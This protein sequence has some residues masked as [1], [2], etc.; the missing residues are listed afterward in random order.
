MIWYRLNGR[1]LMNSWMS[2]VL[3][4]AISVPPF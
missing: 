4:G 3:A 1:E 2:T